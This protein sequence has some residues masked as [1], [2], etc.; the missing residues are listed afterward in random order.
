MGNKICTQKNL[1]QG[2]CLPAVFLFSLSSMKYRVPRV[3]N[4]YSANRIAEWVHA[5]TKITQSVNIQKYVE[6]KIIIQAQIQT[7]NLSNKFHQLKIGPN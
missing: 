7:S 1:Q 5:K 2:Q 4:L 6:S 3:I